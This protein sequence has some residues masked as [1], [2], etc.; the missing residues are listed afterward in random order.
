MRPALLVAFVLMAASA[1]EYQEVVGRNDQTTDAGTTCDGPGCD[2]PRDCSTFQRPVGDCTAGNGSCTFDSDCQA[3]DSN[4][5]TETRR[6]F[7]ASSDC[8]GTPCSI[9]TDCP[10]AERCNRTAGACYD[11]NEDQTCMPCFLLSEDCGAQ[12]CDDQLDICL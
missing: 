7:I 11:F 1:C 3:V 12:M 8:V 9:D 4:C 5:N 2:L 10:P 6:C